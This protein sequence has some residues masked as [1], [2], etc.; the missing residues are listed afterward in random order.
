VLPPAVV[1]DLAARAAGGAIF[2]IDLDS[3]RLATEDGI[4]IGFSVADDRRAALLE[5]MDDIDTILRD[6]LPAI[7][8]FE[9]KHALAQPWLRRGTG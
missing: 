8:A 7:E 5:G 4:S 6:E 9:A 3:L 1:A 2:D